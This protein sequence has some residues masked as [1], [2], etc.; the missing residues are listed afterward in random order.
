MSEP[1]YNDPAARAAIS[2]H[3]AT[4]VVVARCDLCKQTRQFTGPDAVELSEMWTGDGNHACL[5]FM[6][7]D[8]PACE[9]RGEVVD[10]INYWGV[11]EPKQCNLCQGNGVVSAS[12][13]AWFAEQDGAA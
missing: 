6:T 4:Q 13:A 1:I 9:G 3:I 10:Y 7:V 11:V 12:D 2:D 8:C 5:E